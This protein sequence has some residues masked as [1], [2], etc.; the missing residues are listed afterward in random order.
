MAKV[1][2][3]SPNL[4]GSSMA[5]AAIRPWEFAKAL[6]HEHQVV[7]ISPNPSDI[8]TDG[9]KII[10]S[11]DPACRN[12]FRDAD[13]LIAQRLTFPLAL[14]AKFHRV[15]IIIDAY[16][17]GPL[18]LLEHFK[19][20]PVQDRQNKVFSEISNLILSF[21]MA[22]GILCASE[23]Q[24]ELW[25]GFLL[26]Q[27][28]ITPSLYDQDASLR[29]FLAVVPFGL[30]HTQPKRNNQGL[31][32]K[33]RLHQNDKVILWGG[34][35][36]N[37]FD[38]LSLIKAMRIVSRDHSDI[39][40]VFMGI[41]PPDPNLPLTAMSAQAI[42]LAKEYKLLNQCVFFNH[43]WVPY[44]ERQNFLLDADIGVSTHFDHL[45]TH[46][47]FRTRILDY[48]WAELP[49][50]ATQGDAFAELIEKH[51]LGV[52]VPYQNEQA[53]ATAILSLVNQPDHLQKIK[54][55]VAKMREQFHWSSVIAPLNH[56]IKQLS[57]HPQKSGVWHDG[58]A[59]CALIL[60]KLRERGIGGCL[61]TAYKYY[62]RSRVFEKSNRFWLT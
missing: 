61:Y 31:K 58:K 55:N 9:F 37:W 27:K 19:S 29:H 23:K 33:Y 13:I 60:S 48:L 38:P 62:L 56:M 21:K 24:R 16:V 34:G 57:V 1:L 14:S 3:H 26:A 42:Q 49:I 47:A 8:K 54:S 30:S 51:Q 44:D 6:S 7:L 35:I 17:P 59:L 46:F 15:K 25:I 40:L 12:H 28:V 22:H 50:L 2:I 39:K 32:E 10:S 18:E 11:L 43:D 41:K 52:V 45:E 5:G 36:W 20:D 4:I 53:I